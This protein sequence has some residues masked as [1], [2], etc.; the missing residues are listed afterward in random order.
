[1]IQQAVDTAKTI[2]G[3]P[4]VIVCNTVKGKGVD[5]MENN[6]AWHKGV[7]TDA[8]FESVVAQLGGKM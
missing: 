5:F 3:K 6:N 7:P 1:M 8:E 2:Q 4:H